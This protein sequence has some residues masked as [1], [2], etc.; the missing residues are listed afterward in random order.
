MHTL[1]DRVRSDL[2]PEGGR[3]FP[4]STLDSAPPDISEITLAKI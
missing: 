1:D 3:K 2:E 4:F